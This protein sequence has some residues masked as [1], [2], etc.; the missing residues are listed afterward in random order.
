MLVAAKPAAGSRGALSSVGQRVVALRF[1][2][3]LGELG[4]GVV[5]EDDIIAWMKLVE[6]LQAFVTRLHGIGGAKLIAEVHLHLQFVELPVLGDDDAADVG[7]LDAFEVY[8]DGVGE[9]RA[10]KRGERA[11]L[12]GGFLQKY[13]KLLR[14]AL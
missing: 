6:L 10:R 9:E 5:G 3:E 12:A 8:F 11:E 2:Q 1:E 14:G 7:P 13:A 4:Q